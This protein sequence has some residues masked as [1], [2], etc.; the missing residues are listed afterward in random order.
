[1]DPRVR[2]RSRFCL[3]WNLYTKHFSFYKKHSE[4]IIFT[5]ARMKS[6]FVS[7]LF[8][9]ALA[10]VSFTAPLIDASTEDDS[11]PE[12]SRKSRFYKLL[13][14]HS[15]YH[16]LHKFKL[17]FLGFLTP[18]V[19]AFYKWSVNN[20]RKNM[21]DVIN[22]IFFY[23]RGFTKKMPEQYHLGKAAWLSVKKNM[24]KETLEWYTSGFLNAEEKIPEQVHEIYSLPDKYGLPYMFVVFTNTHRV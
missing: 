4:S 8:L 24:T 19:R 13:N 11:T 7:A 9:L 17:K 16:K 14:S 23:E 10:T 21:D 6:L 2:S 12:G 22:E 18:E 20:G 1:M 5:V 3:P 15:S